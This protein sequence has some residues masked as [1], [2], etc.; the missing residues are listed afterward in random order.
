M[1]NEFVYV[2]LTSVDYKKQQENHSLDMKSIER[3]EETFGKIDG[4]LLVEEYV[5]YPDGARELRTYEE[6]RVYRSF[7]KAKQGLVERLSSIVKRT[8]EELAEKDRYCLASEF[9]NVEK[10][11]SMFSGGSLRKTGCI[12]YGVSCNTASQGM[13]RFS[14]QPFI[15]EK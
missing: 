10:H 12:I 4:W 8:R 6:V 15:F 9:M 3:Y 13:Y 1:D 7:G 14:I 11:S 2:P 5:G